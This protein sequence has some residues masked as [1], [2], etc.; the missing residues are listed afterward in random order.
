MTLKKL[1]DIASRLYW[2][3]E[4]RRRGKR[5]MPPQMTVTE[6]LEEAYLKGLKSAGKVE[7]PVPPKGKVAILSWILGESAHIR[8]CDFVVRRLRRERRERKVKG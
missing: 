6:A 7:A 4:P 3:T 5:E 1:H 8:E 2:K